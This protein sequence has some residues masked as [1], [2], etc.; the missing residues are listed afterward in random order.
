VTRAMYSRK[1]V[2]VQIADTADTAQRTEHHTRTEHKNADSGTPTPTEL[3]S[4][5]RTANR[6][7]K[8][9]RRANRM[10]EKRR[11]ERREKRREKSEEWSGICCLG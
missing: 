3:T 5:K 1:R 11:E 2:Q 8:H 9:Q 7:A 10:E 4:Q 6:G